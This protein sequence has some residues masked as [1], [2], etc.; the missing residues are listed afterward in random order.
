METRANYALIGLFTLATLIAGFGF[1]Y[2]FSGRDAAGKRDE[3][4]IVFEGSVAGLNSGSLVLFNGLRVGEVKAI[5][6]MPKDPKRVVATVEIDRA[7]PVK[8]DT[9]ARLDVQMLSGVASISLAGGNPASPDLD[10]KSGQPSPVI[11][12]ERSDFQDL[13][14][15]AREIAQRAGDFLLK[16]EKLIDDNE[17]SINDTLTNVNRFSKALG[18]NAD[19]LGN[20]LSSVGDAAKSVRAV[21]ATADDIL[22]TVNKESLTRMVDNL[23]RFTGSL[24]SSSPDVEKAMKNVASLTAKLDSSADLID[25]VLKAA[26]G[27]LSSPDGKGAFEEVAE[28]ARSIRVLAN[29]LDKRTSEITAGINKF[30]GPGLKEYEALAADGR[31]TLGELNRTMRGLE[32]NPQQ[33]I[34]GGKAPIPEYNGRR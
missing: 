6:L 31:K 33:F 12:A 14:A 17:G 24:G 21:A 22:R 18:D 28:A 20:F 11:I 23:D 30:T 27:F 8:Q 15:S 1:V 16:A 19:G 10:A 32:R 9:K 7:T 34:F 4:R 3:Y 29:N 26:Q 5:A 25:G 2:W 13:L